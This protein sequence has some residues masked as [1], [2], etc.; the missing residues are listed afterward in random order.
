MKELIINKNEA[1]RRADKFLK[2]YLCNANTS[3]IYKMIRKK[4]ITLN[5]KKMTGNEML[6][7]G[8]K[9]KIFFSDETLEKFTAN[10][11]Y[12]NKNLSK[13]VNNIDISKYIIYEDENVIFI[14]KPSGMLSQKADKYDISANEYLIEYLINKN[15]LSREELNRFKPSV[16]NRLDRNTSGLLIFGK[17]LSALQKFSELLKSR[18][19]HKFYL[20]IVKG[21]MKETKTIDGYLCKDERTNKVEVLLEK[22]DTNDRYHN[23][24]HDEYYEI[25]TKYEP[26]SSNGEYTLLKVLLI[27]GKTHQIRAHLASIGFPLVGDS[28]YGNEQVNKYFKDKYKLKH[29]LLHSYKLE[30]PILEGEY[31]YLSEKEFI[32]T[33]SGMFNKIL[34]SEM[35]EAIV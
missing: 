27:T 26:L 28:K 23:K 16:C 22:P 1:N 17:S 6:S 31:E 2:K 29:Q 13:A 10:K 8:D 7:T 33:P 32:A 3:F 11:N 19:L 15:E 20:C 18:N 12:V 5:D 24:Y 35:P 4:N 30:F 14:N 21:Q 9:L 34:K 25:Q